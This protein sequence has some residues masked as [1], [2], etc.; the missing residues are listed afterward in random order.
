MP[1]ADQATPS[2]SPSMRQPAPAG[3]TSLNISA[4]ISSPYPAAVQPPVG[5]GSRSFYHRRTGEV[6]RSPVARSGETRG[7]RP[8]QSDEPARCCALVGGS[9]AGASL[10]G[11]RLA[12]VSCLSPLFPGVPSQSRAASPTQLSRHRPAFIFTGRPLPSEPFARDSLRRDRTGW[13]GE[14]PAPSHNRPGVK[15]GRSLKL[16]AVSP[17]C[18]RWPGLQGLR[19]SHLHSPAEGIG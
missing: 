15:P 2:S 5:A 10:V 1:A 6:L 14:R 9:S 18:H 16:C 12:P 7:G 17:S 11:A 13:G 3:H 4:G 19:L 8:R